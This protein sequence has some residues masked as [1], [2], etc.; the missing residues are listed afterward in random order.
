MTSQVDLSTTVSLVSVQ[1]M[2]RVY[3]VPF[4]SYY[5][6]FSGQ[7]WQNVDFGSNYTGRIKLTLPFDRSTHLLV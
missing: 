3:D 6:F 1:Y 5:A 2:F 4:T 7:Y